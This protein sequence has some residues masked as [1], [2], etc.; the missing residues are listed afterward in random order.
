MP[1]ST[2]CEISQC[3]SPCW[4][5]STIESYL[6]KFHLYNQN[7]GSDQL[8]VIGE[9][10]FVFHWVVMFY[11]VSTVCEQRKQENG[12]PIKVATVFVFS[13]IYKSSRK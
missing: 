4:N 10:I 13:L 6:L 9:D 3:P 5:Q 1:Q 12:V 8:G 11:H 7:K 2:H